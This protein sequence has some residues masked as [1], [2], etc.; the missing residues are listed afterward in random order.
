MANPLHAAGMAGAHLETATINGAASGRPQTKGNPE[1]RALCVGRAYRLPVPA[2]SAGQEL[3]GDR[4]IVLQNGASESETPGNRQAGGPIHGS[5]G[6]V[7]IA[8]LLYSIG[9]FEMR[10][11]G[12]RVHRFSRQVV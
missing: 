8:A 11:N 7:I 4:G 3:F 1:C 10:P 9:S 6:N 5:G 2:C 12:H